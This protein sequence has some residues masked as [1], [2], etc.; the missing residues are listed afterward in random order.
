MR[1]VTPEDHLR[2]RRYLESVRIRLEELRDAIQEQSR[3][4]RSKLEQEASLAAGEITVSEAAECQNHI[5]YK[6][7]RRAQ[8]VAALG[9]WAAVVAASIYAGIAAR[10]LSEMRQATLA[11]KNAANAASAQAQLMRQ[12]L[13]GTIGALIVPR[14]R[15]D[16]VTNTLEIDLDDLRPTPAPIVHVQF[17]VSILS[18]PNRRTFGTPITYSKTITQLSPQGFSVSYPVPAGFGAENKE[19]VTQTKT[20]RMEGSF[21]YQNGFGTQESPTNFCYIYIGHFDFNIAPGQ[22][23]YGPPGFQ[24]CQRAQAMI[25]FEEKARRQATDSRK[26]R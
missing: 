5:E 25:P 12:Q 20:L 14:V 2:L 22:S 26:R 21:D 19:L 1:A 7:N 8:W 13:A 9:T 15:I 10:Q 17:T 23:A 3:A 16:D 11:A 18:F 24:E 4:I 6:K